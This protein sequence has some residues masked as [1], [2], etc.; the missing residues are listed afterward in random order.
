MVTSYAGG[1][2]SST[3]AGSLYD[4]SMWRQANISIVL[5]ASFRR[6]RGTQHVMKGHLNKK[7]KG[8]PLGGFLKMS[9]HSIKST[10]KD[11]HCP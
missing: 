4:I 9:L 5:I 11:R 2:T 3:S 6:Q 10:L 7:V 1:V 8:M